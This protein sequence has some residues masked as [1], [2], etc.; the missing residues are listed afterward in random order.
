VSLTFNCLLPWKLQGV[1]GCVEIGPKHFG[2]IS[3]NSKS[4]SANR[5]SINCKLQEDLGHIRF[6]VE[7][8]CL[9]ISIRSL[10]YRI[11]RSSHVSHQIWNESDDRD[12]A[13]RKGHGVVRFLILLYSG[14]HRKATSKLVLRVRDDRSQTPANAN[15]NKSIPIHLNLSDFPQSSESRSHGGG[16]GCSAGYCQR[17][18]PN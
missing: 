15:H 8:C 9:S 6:S 14:P 7:I 10:R 12:I 17:M 1:D 5:I 13:R 3:P 2:P 11:T 18:C 16:G 4:R